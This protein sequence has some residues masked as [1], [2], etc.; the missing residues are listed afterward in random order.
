MADHRTDRRC[1][2]YSQL[3]LGSLG[4]TRHPSFDVIR[5]AAYAAARTPH[6]LVRYADMK[7]KNR[8][9]RFAVIAVAVT[10]TLLAAILLSLWNQLS[11]EQGQVV[12]S[13]LNQYMGYFFAAFFLLLAAVLFGLDAIFHIYILPLKKITDETALI[14]TSNPSYRLRPLG[15]YETSQLA[16]ILNQFADRYEG[17]QKT[18]NQKISNAREEIEKDKNILAAIMAEL[19]EGVL[20]CNKNGRIILYNRQ[21][22]YYFSAPA[23]NG[24]SG[25]HDSDERFLGLGRSVFSLLDK[26][27]IAH[28]IEKI[29]YRL[30]SEKAESIA[31]YFI[32]P[33]SKQFI[34]RFET[35]PILNKEREMNGFVLIFRD[36]THEIERYKKIESRIQEL[37]RELI[38]Y[39]DKPE[40]DRQIGKIESEIIETLI[41]RNHLSG[42]SLKEVLSFIQKRAGHKFGL[43]INVLIGDGDT[44]I[45]L[46]TYSF[47]EC[48]MFI[49]NSVYE[50][51]GVEEFDLRPRTV[52]SDVYL[53]LEGKGAGLTEDRLYELKTSHLDSG[54]IVVPLT[55]FDVLKQHNGKILLINPSSSGFTGIRI[56]LKSKARSDHPV[57]RI[58]KPPVIAERKPEFYD[59]DLF[60]MEDV[61]RRFNYPI[62]R[63]TYTVF[64][65]ETTGLD[66]EGGDEII[67]IGAVRIVNKKIQ[68]SESFEKMIDPGRPIPFESFKIHGISREMVEGKPCIEKV[69]RDFSKYT[70]DTVLLGHNIAFDMKMLKMKEAS[71]RVV[72]KNPVLDTLLLSAFLHPTRVR[73]SMEEIA[74]RVGV[75]IIGRHTALGDAIATAEIFMKLIP[76]LQQKGVYTL[77]DALEASR[78]T[79][80][81]KIKY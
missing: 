79:Y 35:V 76:L 45:M 27:F 64:D 65:T 38:P 68:Y 39:T 52:N 70:E 15:G 66:P 6:P 33:V 9:I 31:S 13:I 61:A 34:C 7:S 20:I 10:F 78:H 75:D 3:R 54:E 73:H 47:T 18:V 72:F 53:D 37:K 56:I 57:R 71:S 14:F 29:E 43:R 59:F 5:V 24:L 12:L 23:E 41:T 21:A 62:D 48:I 28:A 77:K 16:R 26:G 58:R 55:V 80:Y 30:N 50:E 25:D 32:S 81:A 42:I 17:L 74:K 11:K 2:V 22:K 49:V 8:F 69:L 63:L 40:I 44:T 60:R 1:T 46:D 67:S 4:I 36:I 51:S 19:P